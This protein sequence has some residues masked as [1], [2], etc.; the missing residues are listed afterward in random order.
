ML[1]EASITAFM[2]LAQTLLTVTASDPELIPA[3]SATWRAG[4]W[5]TPAWTTFPKKISSMECGSTLDFSIACLRA[6][7]PS[8]GAVSVFRVP[9]KEPTGVREAATITTSWRDCGERKRGVSRTVTGTRG[10]GGTNHVANKGG[11]TA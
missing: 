2:P 1:W 4:D 8:C 5:P 11:E 10:G 7:T 6:T 3:P 9:F